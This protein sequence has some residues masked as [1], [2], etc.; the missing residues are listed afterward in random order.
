MRFMRDSP[1]STQPGSP[2]H[3]REP[4]GVHEL[5]HPHHL[6]GGGGQDHHAWGDPEAG[7]AVALVGAQLRLIGDA[8]GRADDGP[9]AL[10][11]LRRHAD[12][13]AA[14]VRRAGQRRMSLR[15]GGCHRR[16]GPRLLGLD[17][18]GGSG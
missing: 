3:D 2:R 15:C 5:D 4:G 13:G 11:E 8:V 7:Q 9:D 12:E 18:R 14:G 6:V 1:S 16:R 10:G 17:G